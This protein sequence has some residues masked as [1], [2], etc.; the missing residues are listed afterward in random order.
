MNKK[1]IN[2]FINTIEEWN[3]IKK[4]YKNY[5]KIIL[6]TSPEININE[7]VISKKTIL[8]KKICNRMKYLA[9]DIGNFVNIIFNKTKK[10]HTHNFNTQLSIFIFNFFKLIRAAIPLNKKHLLEKVLILNPISDNDVLNKHLRNQ[11]PYL[12]IFQGQKNLIIKNVKIDKNKYYSALASSSIFLRLLNLG[13]NHIEFIFWRNFWK[14]S[15]KFLYKGKFLAGVDGPFVRE[16]LINLSRKGYNFLELDRPQTKLSPLNKKKYKDVIKITL[17]IKL[18]LSKWLEKNVAEI[19]YRIYLEDLLIFL[20]KFEFNKIYWKKEISKYRKDEIKGCLSTHFYPE[21]FHGLSDYL[22]EKKIPIFNFQ[23][24]HGREISKKTN[25]YYKWFSY[26]VET[27]GDINFTYNKVAEKISNK[28]PLIRGKFIATGTPKVYKKRLH[29]NTRY[30]ILFISTSVCQGMNVG[31][32][33]ANWDDTKKI[34]FDIKCIDLVLKKI[35]KKVLYKNYPLL[36]NPSDYILNKKI[37]KIKNIKMV[38]NNLELNYFFNKKRVIITS[39]ST[40]TLGWCIMSDLPLVFLD[41]EKKHYPLKDELI[42]HFKNS[43][44]YFDT[45]DKFFFKNLRV[46]LNIPFEKILYLWERKRKKREIL[47]KKFFSINQDSAGEFASNIILN[48][49]NRN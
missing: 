35:N 45:T 22:I 38:K 3:Y 41:H 48:I 31:P 34:S 39:R 42:S 33:N 18:L 30:K 10:K 19:I 46:F 2:C 9:N 43:L 32:I 7:F 47:I 14:I 29:F 17:P 1:E 26:A 20:R 25:T 44:F 4:N 6:T 23:H 28:N 37:A 24:G 15:P 49:K 12:R 8:D 40:G 27:M 13:L 5:N 11:N 36:G 21:S 16:T